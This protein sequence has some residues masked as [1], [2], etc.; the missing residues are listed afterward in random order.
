VFLLKSNGASEFEEFIFRLHGTGGIEPA[1]EF[2][3]EAF[4]KIGGTQDSMLSNLIPWSEF[5]ETYQSHFGSTGNVRNV[6][7]CNSSGVCGNKS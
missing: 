1:L 4:D 2:A 3:V 6:G 5:E 7:T